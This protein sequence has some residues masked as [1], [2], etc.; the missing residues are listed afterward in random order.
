MKD[1]KKHYKNKN[2]NKNKNK[3]LRLGPKTFLELRKIHVLTFGNI[4]GV[5]RK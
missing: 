5:G 4:W 1:E 2:K 3:K